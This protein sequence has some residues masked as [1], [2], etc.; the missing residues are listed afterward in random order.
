MKP[1]KQVLKKLLVNNISTKITLTKR[2]LK[3]IPKIVMKKNIIKNDSLVEKV[4]TYKLKNKNVFCGYYDLNPVQGNKILVHSVAKNANTKKDFAE[5]GYFEIDTKNYKYVTTTKA[6][7]W[8]QGSRLRW[9]NKENDIYYNDIQNDE[10]CLVKYNIDSKSK[11][12]V[13][14]YSIYDINKEFTYG[15]SINFSRLQELR[16]GYGYTNINGEKLEK[17]QSNDGI[18]LVNLK[19]KERKLLISLEELAKTVDQELNYYH[20]LNHISFSPDS[21]KIMFFHLWNDKSFFQWRTQLCIINIDGTG[22]KILEN[23]DIVSHYA[24]RSNEELLITGKTKN[25]EDFYRIYEVSNNVKHDLEDKHLYKDGHPII[26]DNNLFYSDTYP[27]EN[28]MQQLFKYDIKNKEYSKI[29][30]VYS[31]PLLNGEKRCDLHP[32]LINK[33]YIAIDTTYE[34]KKREVILVKLKEEEKSGK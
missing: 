29:L 18:F 33:N 5:I 1:I 22:F 16:P 25:M 27:D 11:D 12:I 20:Y 24:W 19:N 32:K 7:C 6:W 21:K 28:C 15:I 8:Q 2:Y 23:D 3:S 31:H 13:V 30:E 17:I 14:P 9:G 4:E 10:F 34:K 26:V